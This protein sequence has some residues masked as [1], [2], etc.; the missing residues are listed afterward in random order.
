MGLPEKPPI[1]AH[2]GRTRRFDPDGNEQPSASD[3]IL[4][5]MDRRVLPFLLALAVA[6]SPGAS[7]ACQIACTSMRTPSAA[8][9]ATHGGSQSCHD[10]ASSPG[11][12][13]S[14]APHAC[15]HDS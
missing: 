6:A 15:N 1:I 9:S 11:P 7:Y 10:A 3:G 14:Q 5:R 8:T 2:A 13:L 12:G 4:E